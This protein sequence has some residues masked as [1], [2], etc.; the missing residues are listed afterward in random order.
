MRLTFD[1]LGLLVGA[2]LRCRG[3]RTILRTTNS[4]ARSRRTSLMGNYIFL[5]FDVEA[6]VW[7]ISF[8]RV[9][10]ENLTEPDDLAPLILSGLTS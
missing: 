6:L 8:G 2:I 4:F 9:L 7:I 10:T 5:R 1:Y 3:V